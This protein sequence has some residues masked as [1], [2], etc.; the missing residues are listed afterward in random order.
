MTKSD[1]LS[2]AEHLYVYEKQLL[3]V[4]G[5]KFNLSQG[6][7]FYWKKEYDLDKKRFEKTENLPRP[8]RIPCFRRSE[9]INRQINSTSIQ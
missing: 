9:W 3:D 1:K 5:M 4:I 7:L 6:T 2:Q 8:T